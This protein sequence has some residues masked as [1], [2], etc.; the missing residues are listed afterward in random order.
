MSARPPRISLCF[1]RPAWDLCI[2]RSPRRSHGCL[3]PRDPRVFAGTHAGLGWFVTDGRGR[4]NRLEVRPVRRLQPFIGFSPQRPPRRGSSVELLWQP[5]DAGTISMGMKLI[6]PDFHPVDYQT[7]CIRTKFSVRAGAM[8]ARM[9]S[10][11]P[12]SAGFGIRPSHCEK[13]FG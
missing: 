10:A 8:P 2:H 12:L 1:L 4:A 11:A 5:I 9:P 3:K 6:N 13:Q 7:R